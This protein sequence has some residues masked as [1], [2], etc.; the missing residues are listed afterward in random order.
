M[1]LNSEAVQQLVKLLSK[2]SPS[3]EE[4]EAQEEVFS[5]LVSKGFENVRTDRVGNVIG[6]KGDGN[7]A[8]LFCS[9]ID[10]VPGMID[11]KVESGRI[12]GRGA[13]DAK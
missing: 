4:G 1:N 9:H 11:V 10:T 2:Y 12:F 5:L 6:E 13:V 8:L 3:G 7:R